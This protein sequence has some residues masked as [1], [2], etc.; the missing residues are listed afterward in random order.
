MCALPSQTAVTET[1]ANVWRSSTTSVRDADMAKFVGQHD[2]HRNLRVGGW[3]IRQS[4][5]KVGHAHFVVMT[6]VRFVVQPAGNERAKERGQ[7]NVHA[8]ARGMIA[9][10]KFSVVMNEHD[11]TGL[12][13]IDYNPFEHDSFMYNGQ[14]VSPDTVWPVVILSNTTAHVPLD[15]YGST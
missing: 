15:P 9:L 7:R 10:T 3:T 2:V 8:F 13:K 12:V 1:H 6:G 11:M 14:P 4:G 5:T